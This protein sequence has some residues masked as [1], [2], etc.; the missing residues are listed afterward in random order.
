MAGLALLAQLVLALHGAAHLASAGQDHC[1]IAQIAHSFAAQLP[2]AVFQLIVPR[3]H[4]SHGVDT[5]PAFLQSE[6][7]HGPP[8]RAPPRYG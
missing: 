7:H 2:A 3:F 1:E 6:P 8:I 5:L 4:R